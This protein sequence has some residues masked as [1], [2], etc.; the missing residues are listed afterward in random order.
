MLILEGIKAYQ[1]L[2][3]NG[4]SASSAFSQD[5][6]LRGISKSPYFKNIT[7]KGG[8][9]MR[10]FTKDI[11]RATLDLDLD[12]INYSIS[13]ESIKALIESLCT[14]EFHFSITGK[15]EE[16]KQQDYHGKRVHIK[17]ADTTNYSISTKIDIGV[18]TYSDIA[19]NQVIV[20]FLPKKE[21]FKI[22]SNSKE[23]IFVEKA[24]ALLRLGQF[25]TRY[26]DIFDLFWL[27]DVVNKEI[28]RHY[29]DTLIF[30]DEGMKEKT[31][32]DARIR[33]EK[34][35]ANKNF[36]QKILSSDKN[37]V[38]EDV[39]KVT[40]DILQFMKNIE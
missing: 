32:Q 38:K 3:L 7:I 11:R 19:Q 28:L 16:L 34:I 9:A 36:K 27:K 1:E 20:D 14:E 23:Q 12:F 22:L 4:A 21:N 33:F 17:I 37:W 26:K 29:F 2:G 25:S 10:N 40:G 39:G 18:H 6:I 8:V 13:E 35:F 24:K 15:I 31:L 30:K 5:L